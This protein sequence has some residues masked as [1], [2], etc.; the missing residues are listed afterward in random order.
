ME[1]NPKATIYFLSKLEPESV[2]YVDDSYLL[3]KHL[4]NVFKIFKI[5]LSYFRCVDSR[6]ILKS[7]FWFQ[8]KN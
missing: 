8:H 1:K 4:L 2:V 6:Y 7:L 5:Q 3:W